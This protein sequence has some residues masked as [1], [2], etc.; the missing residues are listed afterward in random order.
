MI[1]IKPGNDE[2]FIN[3]VLNYW[4]K[5]KLKKY[6][7]HVDSWINQNLSPYLSTCIDLKSLISLSSPQIKK[8]VDNLT[9]ANVKIPPFTIRKRKVVSQASSVKGKKKKSFDPFKYCYDNC[10]GLREAVITSHSVDVCPYCN[11]NWIFS[12]EKA[13]AE[14]DH[15]YPKET[16]PFLSCC[17]NNLVPVCHSCNHKKGTS[18]IFFNPFLKDK[19]ADF[20]FGF[21][22][23]HQSFVIY[24]TFNDPNYEKQFKTLQLDSLYSHHIKALEEMIN[25]YDF[26]NTPYYKMISEKYPYFREV[27]E[28]LFSSFTYNTS[29]LDIPLLKFKQDVLSELL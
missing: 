19:I 6:F 1:P 7:N 24:E 13:T 18:L 29:Y 4:K 9:K 8:L 28:M 2:E 14:I 10:P 27:K 11:R 17:Y 21:A 3:V 16:Y 5:R 20:N 26:F 22:P 12:G 25:I 15:F 23:F